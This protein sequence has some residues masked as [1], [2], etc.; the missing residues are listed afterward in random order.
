[1]GLAALLLWGTHVGYVVQHHL[2]GDPRGLLL[3]G[4]AHSHPEV[5]RGAPLVEGLGYDGQFFAALA[6]DPFFSRPET[7]AAMDSAFYRGSR[8]GLP[9][10][11]WLLGAGSARA[12]IF[13]YQLLCWVGAA[14]LPWVLARWV[15]D[16]GG[17]P[18]W[19][20][21]A[22][23]LAGIL[24]SVYGS[25][26]D[27]AAVTL[28]CSAIWLHRSGRRGVVPLLVLAI[29]VKETT[30]FLAAPLALAALRQRQPRRAALIALPPLVAAV[31]WRA[32]LLVRLGGGPGGSGR[33]N[34]DWPLV[35]VPAKL[36]RPLDLGEAAALAALLLAIVAAVALLPSLRRWEAPEI[37]F[38]ASVLVA[39]FLSR[40]VYLPNWFNHGRVLLAVPALAIVVGE[41]QQSAWRRSLLRLLPLLWTVPAVALVW[42]WTVAY[43]AAVAIVWWLF[44][45]APTGPATASSGDV[46]RSAAPP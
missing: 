34:F 29:L 25:L 6:A 22:A 1:M 42:G 28:C 33:E 27:G 46:S 19:A 12:A 14:L 26:P 35:W 36:A 30:F 13:I 5:L 43:G 15:E 38:A 45:G 7:A 20:A 9:L 23:L 37:C 24:S 39:L 2:N 21:P 8:V 10:V 40:H 11:A 44:R 3:L 17:S 4:T 31:A 32:W 41:R 18:F 16:E